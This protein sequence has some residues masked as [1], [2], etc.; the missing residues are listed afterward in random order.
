[1]KSS[2]HSEKSLWNLQS[3]DMFSVSPILFLFYFAVLTC[4]FNSSPSVSPISVITHS[5]L[6][7][8]TWASLPPPLEC[9]QSLSLLPSV[10]DHLCPL[11]RPLS[12]T[13]SSCFCVL[14][15]MFILFQ[16]DLLWS[17][18]D[19]DFFLNSYVC[20]VIAVLKHISWFIYITCI[21]QMHLSRWKHWLPYRKS[22]FS[23]QLQA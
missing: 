2:P 22:S 14:T 15:S 20:C 19:L 1:M 17:Y 23:I 13:V 6:M 21:S 18:S 7:C 8:H 16:T 11:W 5:A 3:Y 9:I 10:S 4:C 12:A